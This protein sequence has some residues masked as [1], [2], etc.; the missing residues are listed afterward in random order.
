M[1][2]FLSDTDGAELDLKLRV[3]RIFLLLHLTFRLVNK[4]VGARGTDDAAQWLAMDW[5][6]VPG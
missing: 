3:F 5:A 6:A 2:Q 4:A 1:L